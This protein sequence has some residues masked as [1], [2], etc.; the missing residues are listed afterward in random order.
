MREVE[1]MRAGFPYLR[2]PSLRAYR[3]LWI[4]SAPV[5]IADARHPLGG[6]YRWT[7]VACRTWGEGLRVIDRWWRARNPPQNLVG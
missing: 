6:F 5:W 4:V 1:L 3:S 2:K 7:D